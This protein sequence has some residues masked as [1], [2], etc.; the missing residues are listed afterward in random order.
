MVRKAMKDVTFSDGTVIPKGTFVVV[1]TQLM[2]CDNEFYD[3]A[4][5]FDPFRFANMRTEDSVDA[6]HQFSTTS[7]EYLVFGYGRHAW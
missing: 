4:G 6:Q 3:D 2:H 5:V 1:A 7:P